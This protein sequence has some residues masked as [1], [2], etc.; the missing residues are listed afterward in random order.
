M[1]NVHNPVVVVDELGKVPSES[2][3][4]AIQLEPSAVPSNCSVAENDPLI[5]TVAV[6]A[7]ANRLR[8]RHAA[9]LAQVVPAAVRLPLMDACC[10]QRGTEQ[11]RN[12]QSSSFVMASNPF[13]KKV[14][15]IR[16]RSWKET[17]RTSRRCD[18][19]IP[20]PCR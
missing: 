15:H 17:F 10:A 4:S 11:K 8:T 12:K 18:C 2:P 20:V 7:S 5:W 13:S 6:E 9:G 19:G 1:E 14:R 3:T 16:S